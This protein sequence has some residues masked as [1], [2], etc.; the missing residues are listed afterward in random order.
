MAS[1]QA[2]TPQISS[3][4]PAT[5]FEKIFADYFDYGTCHF[6]VIGDRFFGWAHVFGTP[7]ETSVAG[8]AALVGL[9]G[10]Y[11]DT[12]GVPKE[13]STDGGPEFTAFV[14]KNFLQTWGVNH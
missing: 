11:F 4:P 1:S 7:S 9:L 5:P 14:T 8:A 12:F 6:L 3:N 2:A 13:I 10:A